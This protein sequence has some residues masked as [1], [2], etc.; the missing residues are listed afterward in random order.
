MNKFIYFSLL[1]FLFFSCKNESKKTATPAATPSA[2]VAKQLAALDNDFATKY[3]QTVDYIDIVLYNQGFSMNISQPGSIQSLFGGLTTQPTMPAAN[4]PAQGRIF[5][6][7]KGKT[8][9]EADLH[10]IPNQCAIMVF[11]IDGKRT[12]ASQMNETGINIFS[13]YFNNAADMQSKIQNGQ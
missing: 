3:L 12:Y 13:N 8:M 5:F 9:T 1:F 7:S 11:Y 4:C 6:N 10:F 2:P